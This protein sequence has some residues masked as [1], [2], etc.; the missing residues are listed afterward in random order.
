MNFID[1]V[2][3]KEENILGDRISYIRK[4]TSKNKRVKKP[5]VIPYHQKA[6]QILDE[7]GIHKPYLLGIIKEDTPPKT[8]ITIIDSTRKKIVEAVN[9][10]ANKLKIKSHLV[11]YT[12]RHSAATKLIQNGADIVTIKELLGHSSITVTERYAKSLEMEDQ[13]KHVSKL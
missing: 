7:I 9:E 2:H 12:A 11:L 3:L 6:K 13:M 8:K 4:K 10:A 1:M 5:I